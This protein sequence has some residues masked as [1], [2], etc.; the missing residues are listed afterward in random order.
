MKKS[1]LFCLLFITL[2]AYANPIYRWRDAQGHL[3]YDESKP[4]HHDYELIDN[5]TLPPANTSTAPN[6]LTQSATEKSSRSRHVKQSKYKSHKRNKSADAAKQRCRRYDEQLETIANRLHA[7]Y[8]EP[9]GN[10]LRAKRRQLE[11][12]VRDEC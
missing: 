11:Q 2:C 4:L 1:L 10:R 9:T 3:H 12:R 5:K 6:T 7:G 8:R